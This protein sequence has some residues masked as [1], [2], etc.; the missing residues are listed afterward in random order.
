M[1]TLTKILGLFAV[2]MLF[3]TSACVD[4]RFG[5]NIDLPL[6]FGY[7]EFTVNATDQQG[8]MVLAEET[9]A[10]DLE[11]LL[12]DKGASMKRLNSVVVKEVIFEIVNPPQADFNL[13]K[14]AQAYIGTPGGTRLVVAEIEDIPNEKLRSLT[15][16]VTTQEDVQT[17]ISGSEFVFSAHGFTTAPIL[18]PIEMRAMIKFEAQ[19]GLF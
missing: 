11:K 18:E 16:P 4:G 1:K 17:Y 14:N 12:T 15:L 5:L 3:T 10:T 19:I 6:D 2:M 9:V 7:I 8:E 13:L